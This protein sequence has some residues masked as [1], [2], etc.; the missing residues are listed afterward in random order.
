MISETEAKWLEE[1]LPTLFIGTDRKVVSGE[2]KFT[3]A[4]DL[5]SNQFT[6]LIHPGQTARG[7]I[8]MGTY[9]VS[10]KQGKSP[11]AVP[12][13]QV[14]DEHIEKSTDR[15]FYASGT[16]CLCGPVEDIY[17]FMASEFSFIKYLERLVIPFLYEQSYYD[18]HGKWPWGEYAHGAAGIF[19]SYARSGKTREHIEA[20]INKLRS[21]TNWPRIR[22]VLSGKEKVTE[23]SKCFCTKPGQIRRC[24][25]AAWFAIAR[26]RAAI[27]IKVSL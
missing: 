17:E 25:G 4:Y 10:I 24:H 1:N 9:N 18:K 5:S 8:L 14:E 26:L 2:L 22:N 19:K 7:V 6:W 13:L 23:T 16:A 27:E 12:M 20:C 3:A 21:D 15:H 11:T